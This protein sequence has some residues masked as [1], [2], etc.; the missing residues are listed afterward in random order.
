MLTGQIFLGRRREKR[1]VFVLSHVQKYNLANAENL[2]RYLRNVKQ[3]AKIFY[4]NT[5]TVPG[6]GVEEMQTA[7]SRISMRTEGSSRTIDRHLVVDTI[8]KHKICTE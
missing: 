1:S 5:C 6:W 7:S 2:H 4:G 3:G 8:G